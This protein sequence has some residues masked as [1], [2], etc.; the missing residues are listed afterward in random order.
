MQS[1]II[2]PIY[3]FIPALLAIPLIAMQFTDD[4]NWGPGDYLIM[5]GMLFFALLFIDLVNRRSIPRGLKSIGDLDRIC[6]DAHL[7]FFWFWSGLG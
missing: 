2:S 3:L 7:D 5:G 6:P 1:K 4:V